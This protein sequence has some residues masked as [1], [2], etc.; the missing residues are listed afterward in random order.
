MAAQKQQPNVKDAY[1][2]E[3]YTSK[4]LF[5]SIEE[6]LNRHLSSSE[7]KYIKETLI[8]TNDKVFTGGD[9]EVT[10]KLNTYFASKLRK[11]R[12][13]YIKVDTH[14]ILKK[15]IGTIAEREA[16]LLFPPKNIP[17]KVQ[18]IAYKYIYLDTKHRVLN[19]DG[20][21]SFEWNHMNNST[22][23][24]QG[25]FNTLGTLRDIVSLKVMEMQLPYTSSADTPLRR[26][27]LYIKELGAQSCIAQENRK[28]HFMFKAITDS[29][30]INLD[31]DNMNKGIYRFATPITHLDSI[32]F[33]FG[34]PTQKVTFDTDRM[35]CTISA[36]NP[37]VI[38][39][40]IAH[41][42]RPGDFVTITNFS[43]D[44]AGS[45]DDVA[46]QNIHDE[47]GHTVSILT[48]TTVSIPV[49]LSLTT[50]IAG[51]KI[52]VYFESK[53]LISCLEVGYLEP[54]SKYTN[55]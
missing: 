46:I 38:T 53:R 11:I 32:T 44:A 43:T 31:P 6:S 17:K 9:I 2:S 21:K 3:V 39:T 10:R 49:D 12:S 30:W 54:D 1:L 41:N 8:T 19:S 5:P 28:F 20:T 27:T 23:A 42:L 26:V 52:S 37:A 50:P 40:P 25:T 47:G 15:D 35:Q 22:Y 18:A 36:T 55:L 14:E 4:V 45:A 33:T 24:G 13:K 51:L 34:A 7:S 48:A 29:G 16:K